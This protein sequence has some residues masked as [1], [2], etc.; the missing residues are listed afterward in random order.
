MLF[1]RL[2]TFSA[3]TALVLLSACGDSESDDTDARESDASDIAPDPDSDTGGHVADTTTDAPLDPEVSP[4]GTETDV[5]DEET[6]DPELCSYVGPSGTQSAVIPLRFGSVEADTLSVSLDG[7]AV[8]GRF[9]DGHFYAEGGL[10]PSSE[11]EW[12]VVRSPGCPV[13]L[14]AFAT[15]TIGSPV[16]DPE[17][18][19]GRA[20]DMRAQPRGLM[21]MFLLGDPYS[22]GTSH[23]VRID[24]LD[25]DSANLTFAIIG[26]SRDASGGVSPSAQ[27]MCLASVT[28]TGAWD[29]SRVSVAGDVLPVYVLGFYMGLSYVGVDEPTLV[30]LLDWRAEFVVHPEGDRITVALLTA[31]ADTRTLTAYYIDSDEDRR[32]GDGTPESFCNLVSEFVGPAPCTSCDDGVVACFPLT[33]WSRSP[34]EAVEGLVEIDADQRENLGCEGA[35]DN[36][37]DDDGDGT[38]DEDIE[39]DPA[40]WP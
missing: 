26:L 2:A 28:T 34:G 8:E 32:E 22:G 18:L 16:A 25:G 39:C 7:A 11:Y 13:A 14:G 3:L 19:I 31:I 6:T 1:H 27:D 12:S 21:G 36:G 38:A 40:G 24:S 9:E 15:S 23:Q 5:S 29:G 10:R 37:V 30:D 20:F 35:C 33:L 4:D 17:A